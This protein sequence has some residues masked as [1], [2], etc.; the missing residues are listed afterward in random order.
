MKNADN[1]Y[2]TK[3]Y[4]VKQ[5]IITSFSETTMITR[6]VSEDVYYLRTAQRDAEYNF[7]FADRKREING[8]RIRTSMF[9]RKY[10]D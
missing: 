10:I 4:I 1:I 2:R 6:L 5:K 9:T 3:D 8:K 7:I